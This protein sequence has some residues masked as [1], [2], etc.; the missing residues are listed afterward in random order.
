MH[1]WHRFCINYEQRRDK[2]KKH[3]IVL[4]VFILFI[5]GLAFSDLVTFKVGYFIP[6]AK[7]DL[8]EIEFEN[9]DF[10]KSNFQT[11]NFGF[12]YEYF[13]SKELSLMLSVDGYSKQKLGSY[14][15]YG[16]FS[17]EE[18]YL[19]AFF[20]EGEPIIHNFSVSITPIQVSLKISP[21]GRRQKLMPYVGGG[22]GVYVW[23]VRLLGDMINFDPLAEVEFTDGTIG[24]PVFSQNARE[25]NKFSIG[26]HVLGGIM[27]PLANRIS[28]SA[29]FKYNLIKGTLTE[30]FEGFEPFDLSGYQASLGLNYWF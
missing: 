20:N 11:T 6:R 13:F 24:N 8:W 16:A 23:N 25:E 5:P 29:E 26:Y 10:T 19:Y 3:L 27:F 7:S 18:G 21:L 28:I 1:F 4:T 22:V 14:R 30:Y 2:M 17:D 15:D 12:E 9:M